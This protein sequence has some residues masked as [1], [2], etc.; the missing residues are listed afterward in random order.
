LQ[1]LFEPIGVVR[2]P[3]G[4]RAQAPRQPAAER[5]RGVSGRIELFA[6]RGFEDAL[7]GLEAWSHAWVL[8]V[9]HRNVE[10]GR[11]W[12]PKVQPPRAAAKIGVFATRSPHRPN[13][14]GMS[15]VAIERVD[16][17]V[18]HVRNLDLLDGTPV[19][20][21]KP[22]VAYA[23]AYPD[24]KAGWLEARD[25]RPPWRVAFTVEAEAQLAWLGARG[26]ELRP[27]I[28]SALAPGPQP[29]AY[30]RIRRHG[31]GL[32]LAAKEWRIDFH[33]QDGSMVVSG[34]TSGYGA[35][36]L[37]TGAAPELHR[38][39]AAAFAVR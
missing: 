2:S 27:V 4:E 15:A 17:R 28:E 30:R 12:R 22:Y 1:Y 34:V 16:G 20:D 5:A 39:F 3:F 10:Q 37:A 6:G 25:P 23:D 19:L 33:V 18:V 9:F 38:A 36:Q 35:R 24:A 26:V 21:L 8:F 31:D 7:S 14:I 29:H 32:R 11:G 13:P